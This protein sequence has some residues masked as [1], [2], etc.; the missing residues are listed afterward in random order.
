[1][2]DTAPPT[3]SGRIKNRK[4]ARKFPY[5]IGRTHTGER[6]PGGPYTPVQFLGAGAVVGLLLLTYSWWSRFGNLPQNIM[7]LL[8][9]P[10]AA[11]WLL[12]RIPQGGRNPFTVAAGVAKGATAGLT[13][14]RV[15]GIPVRL[16]RPTAA[17]GTV[18]I[19]EP[20]ASGPARTASA[21]VPAT[22]ATIPRPLGSAHLLALAHAQA[23]R[24]A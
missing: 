21:P 12:G 16:P 10:A 17:L 5:L 15:E 23:R 9:L 2:T 18:T 8:G 3:G 13:T 24:A 11:L 6:I 1:M 19:T 22:A 7:V 4:R 14:P 20:P